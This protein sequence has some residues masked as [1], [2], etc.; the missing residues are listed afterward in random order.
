MYGGTAG[1]PY[2]SCYHQAC[3]TVDNLSTAALNEL[4]DA[5]AHSIM[6]LAV[7]KTGFFEDGSR[8][9]KSAQFDV[10]SLDYWGSKQIR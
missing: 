2:D 9:A 7:S 4:G 1:A 8:M 3:D 10:N 5:A 6:T